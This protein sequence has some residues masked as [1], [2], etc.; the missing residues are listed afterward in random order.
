MSE[1]VGI[2]NKTDPKR[3]VNI[4]LREKGD[5]PYHGFGYISL[6]SNPVD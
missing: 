6:F 5:G 3:A 2:K 4:L 1:L